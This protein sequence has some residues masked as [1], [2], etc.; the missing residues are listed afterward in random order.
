MPS[1]HQVALV[2]IGGCCSFAAWAAKLQQPPIERNDAAHR[3]LRELVAANLN[4]DAPLG[5]GLC[6]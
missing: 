4:Y 5:D 2:Q 3:W 1:V 6:G